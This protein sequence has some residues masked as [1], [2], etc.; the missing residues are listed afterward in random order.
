M[1][2]HTYKSQKTTKIYKINRLIDE[3]ENEWYENDKI[4]LSRLQPL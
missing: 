3:P 1:R 2:K 4:Q